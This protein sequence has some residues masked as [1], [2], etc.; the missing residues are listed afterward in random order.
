MA[1]GSY[2]EACD[3][4]TGPNL[5]EARVA[6]PA[7]ELDLER[8]AAVGDPLPGEAQ[9]LRF[10]PKPMSAFELRRWQSRP[11]HQRFS[12][13]GRL[14]RVGLAGTA[15]RCGLVTSLLAARP[16]PG[17]HGGR[18]FGALRRDLG[19]RPAGRLPRPG[20]PRGPLGRPP[21]HVLLRDERLALHVRGRQRPRGRPRAVLRRPRGARRR[22]DGARLVLRGRPRREGRRPS[23]PLGRP[24][25]GD[26]SM[27]IRS[28]TRAPG[29]TRPTSSVASTSCCCRS[30]ASGTSAA[31]STC[32]GGSGATRSPS[33]T[34][35]TSPRGRSARSASR[36]ST[37]PAATARS[38]V[39]AATSTGRRSSS[40]TRTAGSTATAACGASTPATGSPASER[41]AG[42]KYTRTG[43]VRQ[44]W[45]D[46]LGF[47]GLGKVAPPSQAIPALEARIEELTADASGGRG[48]GRGAGDLAPG[49]RR[50]DGGRPGRGRP[51]PL[52]GGTGP[53][54]HRSARS[55]WPASARR[56]WSSARRS[57]PVATG[58]PPCEPAIATTR[59]S[60]ST[61]RRSPSRRRSR[62]VG[63]SGRRGPRSASGCSSP[64]WRSSSGS[65]SCRRAWRSSCCIGSYLAIESFFDRNVLE[66]VLR[67]TV[68]LAIDLGADPRG[69][70]P[71][72][73]VPGRTARPRD[74]PGPRQ[75]R[76]SP[77]APPALTRRAS[78]I[79]AAVVL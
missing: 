19:P 63:R 3:L 5:R 7:G 27:A 45:H 50:G 72:R 38:S 61:T 17:R 56:T 31:R 26:P 58:W 15:R 33:P 16:R 34:R 10:V 18:R 75:P 25:D 6:I 42:P 77:A 28:S 36:S 59:A 41:P 66:L 30:R 12:A 79:A 44:S 2:V 8:L 70:L 46:P 68:V 11:E 69:H 24:A 65:G 67:I 49:A 48:R 40:A 55:G 60:I 29:R 14:A 78:P 35:A 74:H 57:P 13:P 20:R 32:C 73:A 64:R 53:G 4:L 37:T 51:R 71:A 52:S 62:A 47:A 54:A 23:P 76:R 1:A 39:R 43:S 22:H 9:F 21:L